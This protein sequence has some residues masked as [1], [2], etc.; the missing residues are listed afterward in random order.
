MGIFRL[1]CRAAQKIRLFALRA[2][3]T[4]SAPCKIQ[5]M[6]GCLSHLLME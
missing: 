5:K 6:Q 1:V 4:S 3:K 2:A